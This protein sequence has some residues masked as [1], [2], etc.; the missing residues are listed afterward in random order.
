MPALTR[1]AH[2][3]VAATCVIATIS[4]AGAVTER[5]LFGFVLPAAVLGV[6][7]AA[8]FVQHRQLR[9][10]AA[11]GIV[12]ALVWSE[13]ANV[14]TGQGNGPAARSSFAA[15]ACAAL[16]LSAAASRF[17]ATFLVP[18]GAIVLAAVLLGAGGEVRVVAMVTVAAAVVALAVVEASYRRWVRPADAPPTSRRWSVGALALLVTLAAAIAAVTQARHDPRAPHGPVAGAHNSLVTPPWHDP[19][20]KTSV[21]STTSATHHVRHRHAKHLTPPP[22]LKTHP[23]PHH[24]TVLTIALIAILALIVL[25]LIGIAIRLAMIRRAWTRIRRRLHG[26]S[27]DGVVGAWVWARLRLAAYRMPLPARLSPDLVDRGEPIHEMP[28]NST[29]PLRE[30]ARVVA[31]AA[32]GGRDETPDVDAKEA[33]E[34]SDQVCAAAE[35]AMSRLGHVRLRLASPPKT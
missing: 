22:Q 30:L 1:R 3:A 9:T 14:I 32:F 28:P 29:E 21:G 7:A 31:P 20:P 33:W 4:F 8:L 19:F 16:A 34:L 26:R 17:P 27:T 12:G 15:G 35:A 2:L 5:A 13:I 23:R 11:T 6:A 24:H 10:A 18:V 25:L